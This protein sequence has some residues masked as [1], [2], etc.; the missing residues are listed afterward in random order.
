MAN[1]ATV[2]SSVRNVMRVLLR[3]C[4]IGIFRHLGGNISQQ[5]K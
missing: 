4:S 3:E 1:L 2:Y 5:E